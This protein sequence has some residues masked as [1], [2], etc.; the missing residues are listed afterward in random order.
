M[1]SDK[2][3]ASSLCINII[4][5]IKPQMCSDKKNASSLCI[6]IITDIKPQMGKQTD[7]PVVRKI[8]SSLKIQISVLV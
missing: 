6:N 4:T 8:L 3:N 2:K 7:L 5:D 1:C